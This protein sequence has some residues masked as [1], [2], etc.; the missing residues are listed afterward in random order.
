MDGD[1]KLLIPKG[2]AKGPSEFL[3]KISSIT[4]VP[5]DNISFWSKDVLGAKDIKSPGYETDNSESIAFSKIL[6][7]RVNL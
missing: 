7:T 4:P 1:S 2:W 6:S 3:I 5:V